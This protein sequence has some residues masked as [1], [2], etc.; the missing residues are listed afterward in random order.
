MEPNARRNA[1]R[2]QTLA[3]FALIFPV[4]LLFLFGIIQFGILYGGQIGLVNAARE[5]ARYAAVLQTGSSTTASAFQTETYDELTSKFLPRSVVGYGAANLVTSGADR[6]AVCYFSRSN[7]DG[8]SFSVFVRVQVQYR[9]PLLIP[10]VGNI[11]DGIDGTPDQAFRL[12][13]SEEMRV[14]NPLISSDPGGL[15]SCP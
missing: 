3:E 8:T 11:V 4:L 12:G 6:T 13:A 7:A 15:P 14:E 5:A 1:V 2:G 10:I 9:H